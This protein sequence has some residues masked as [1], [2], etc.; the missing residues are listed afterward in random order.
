MRELVEEEMKWLSRKGLNEEEQRS[1]IHRLIF[2]SECAS[3]SAAST[4]S[5]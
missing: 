3:S 2:M 4:T 5:V 1:L